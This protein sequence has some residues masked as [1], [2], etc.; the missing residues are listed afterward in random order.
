MTSLVL[1]CLLG[2]ATPLAG[3]QTPPPAAP[4]MAPAASRQGQQGQGQQQGQPTPQGR[5]ARGGTPPPTAAP[6]ASTKPSVHYDSPSLQN[7]RVE[8]T[9]TDSL[10]T[11]GPS[12]KTVTMMVVDNN[13]GQIR[14]QGPSNY[15]LNVDAMP[16]VRPDGRIYL[17]L[18]LFYV[19]EPGASASGT[20]RTPATLN[21][22]VSVILADGKPMLLS[23][24]ADPRGD[25]KVTVE[26][27][28]TVVK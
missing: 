18:S 11:E 16:H 1:T 3:Q 9:L 26:V 15:S 17:S 6:E 12:K 5:G 14:S 25:R 23:Q 7:I 2:L 13:G 21:E 4:T 19:P 27:T 8:V 22:A 20:A 10:Q 24:S 28:A